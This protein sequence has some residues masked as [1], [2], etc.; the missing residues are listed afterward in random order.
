MSSKE[1]RLSVGII[2]ALFLILAAACSVVVPP[3]ENLD[4]IEHFGVIRHVAELG[5]LPI[6]GTDEAATYHCRQEASQPPL[7]YFVSAGLVRLLGLRADE[8][9]WELSLNPR[10]A[11]GPGAI[12]LYDNRMVF[13]HNPNR[14]AFPW[15]GTMLMLHVLRLLSTLLQLGTVII[16]YRLARLVFPQRPGISLLAM[17]F[18]A[19]NPQFI[20][21]ASGVNNDNLVVPLATLGIYVLVQVWREGLTSR[22]AIGLGVLA[23]L[24]GLSKLSGWLLLG[25]AGLVVLARIVRFRDQWLQQGA[26]A[27]L[28]PA[29]ALS[30]AGWWLW[31]NWQLYGDPT[32][33]QPMLALVGV[34][35]A[36]AFPFSVLQLMFRSFW[37]QIPC[38]FYPPP[39]YWPYGVLAGVGL[40]GLAFGWR[41]LDRSHRAALVLSAVW[42]AIVTISWMRWD[43]MTPATG[44]RL[45]FP[46]LPAL[47]LILAAGI[48]GLKGFRI[49]LPA[50]VI[51]LVLLA[52]VAVGYILPGFFA[53]PERTFDAASVQPAHTVD[54][55]FGDTIRLRGYDIA[56]DD[57]ELV[58]ELTLYWEA[59]AQVT[60]DYVMALQLVSPVPGDTTLRLNY[61]S[62]PG[63]GTYPTSAWRPE[64]IIAD[65]YRLPLPESN[66]VTQAWDLHAVLYS[67]GGDR[68]PVRVNGLLVGDQAVL[69]Q[70]RVPGNSPACAENIALPQPVQYGETIM[71]TDVEIISSTDAVQLTLCWQ[72]IDVV[73]EDY[74]VFVHLYDAAGVLTATADGPPA[75]GA[76]PT[77][78]WQPLD[79]VR[80]ERSLPPLAGIDRVTVGLYNP[81]DG[82]RLPALLEGQSLPNSEVLVW[83]ADR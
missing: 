50:T 71:L 15:Q 27:L 45:L 23:G 68:L 66:A 11:C 25:F 40:I 55:L 39:F 70:M 43:S 6:H 64:E 3:F 46:A 10:V 62:W 69:T 78:L 49:T 60:E 57:N 59:L 4:E 32:A 1:H 38:S 18:V 73:S 42:F 77:R 28:I 30:I 51:S 14:E 54:V 24:A 5:Y 8:G 34:R 82:V 13:Y 61:N 37:G 65:V 74:T 26:W 7:Y 17:S 29:I 31:R 53:P 12:N 19:F 81:A 9:D 83:E 56:F 20:L 36:P 79:I 75:G 63:H 72:P 80:D 47:A 33:L 16:T 21:V 44:G 2:L 22:R 48:E 67:P 52:G 58:L 76:F 41:K 35:D